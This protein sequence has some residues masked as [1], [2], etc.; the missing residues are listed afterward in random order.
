MFRVRIDELA[1]QLSIR[2][3]DQQ[4]LAAAANVSA[5]TVCRLMAGKPVRGLTAI[6]IAQALRRLPTLDELEA[7]VERPMPG[8][9]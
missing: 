7:I 8:A 5:A 2:G 4:T 9:A 6:K 1:Y 3:V